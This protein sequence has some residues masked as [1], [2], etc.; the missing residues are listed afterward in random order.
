MATDNVYR[1]ITSWNVTAIS[2]SRTPTAVE[3]WGYHQT[4]Y[5]VEDLKQRVRFLENDLI[6][7]KQRC[8]QLENKIMDLDA[9]VHE[10]M[11]AVRFRYIDIK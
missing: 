3:G 10:M 1:T 6:S 8:T 9:M 2:W 4:D 11:D 5:D 7:T